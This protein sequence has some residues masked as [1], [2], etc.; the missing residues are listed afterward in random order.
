[1][2]TQGLPVVINAFASDYWM[3]GPLMCQVYA[4]IGGIFGTVSIVTMVVIGYDRYN[5]IVCGF[6][7]VKLNFIKATV[8]ILLVWI[9]AVLACIPPFL[10][11]GGYALGKSK[12]VIFSS[13]K[14]IERIISFLEG[15]FLTCSYDFLSEDWNK[16]SFIIYAFTANYC[17]PMLCVI[18]FY[19]QIVKAVV[20]HEAALR[21]QA[22]KMNVESLR[23]NTVSLIT[24]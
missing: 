23:S 18:F 22:K 5:V 9:Y 21:A 6:K 1:M 15:L 17:I 12:F 4:C 13:L 16:R 8:I 24:L 14:S 7:G 3:Y 11:W 20:A 10:G 2:T 19:S